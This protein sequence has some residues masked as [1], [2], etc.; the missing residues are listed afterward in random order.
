[1]RLCIWPRNSSRSPSLMQLVVEP[2]PLMLA[3]NYMVMFLKGKTHKRRRSNTCT[4]IKVFTRTHRTCN[5]VH[6]IRRSVHCTRFI[7]AL[8]VLVKC[9]LC[10]R[11]M[12]RAFIRVNKIFPFSF[13]TYAIGGSSSSSSSLV[14]RTLP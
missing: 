12:L 5:Y 4:C 6:T 11:Y 8:W 3:R 13:F 1:M 9:L 7:L 2:F 14:T 10:A